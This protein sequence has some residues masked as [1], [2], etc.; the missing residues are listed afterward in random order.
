MS[1]PRLC[2]TCIHLARDKPSFA[3]KMYDEHIPIEITLSKVKCA[4]Y[5][6]VS[7]N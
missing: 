3:C 2:M 5:E 4:A 6:K 1:K 7:P